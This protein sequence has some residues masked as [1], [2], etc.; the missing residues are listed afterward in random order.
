MQDAL[1]VHHCAP[2]GAAGME[3]LSAA[4]QTIAAVA[5]AGAGRGDMQ[6]SLPALEPPALDCLG[7]LCSHL[8]STACEGRRAYVEASSRCLC[9]MLRMCMH[10]QYKIHDQVG[11]GLSSALFLKLSLLARFSMILHSLHQASTPS[12]VTST[13][14]M[15][16]LRVMNILLSLMYGALDG[17]VS[18]RL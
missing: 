2:S 7:T 1:Q 12:V 5:A 16:E 15:S 10:L 8:C 13:L 18:A 9:S 3:H 17:S 4:A 6:L 11:S 14:I